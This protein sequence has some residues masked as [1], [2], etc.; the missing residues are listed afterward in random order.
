MY[1]GRKADMWALG[2][3]LFVCLM[4]HYPY[5]V[6]GAL[7][8]VG[9]PGAKADEQS[10]AILKELL[11]EI[12][13]RWHAWCRHTHQPFSCSVLTGAVLQAGWSM[14]RLIDGAKETTAELRDLLSKMLEVDPAKRLHAE[15]VL[16][17]PW[18]QLPADPALAALNDKPR[19]WTPAEV[20]RLIAGL[21][22]P[23]QPAPASS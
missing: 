5:D 21:Q 13:V 14:G 7:G 4:G 17:H 3:V 18:L 8:G 12:E 23:G 6:G 11:G 19:V 15:E 9:G 22:P 16:R 10:L 1:D 2:V 20:D